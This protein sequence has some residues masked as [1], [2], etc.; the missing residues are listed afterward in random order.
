M[1]RQTWVQFNRWGSAHPLLYYT[2]PLVAWIVFLCWGSLAPP[3]ELPQFNFAQADKFEH[4]I[5]YCTLAVLLLRGW[6]R[7]RPVTLGACCVIGLIASA[8][9]L[10]LEFMQRM[11]SYRTFDLWD[12][13]SN[14]TGALL[15]LIAW[16][17]YDAWWRRSGPGAPAPP[18][19]PP[20][21]LT[22]SED[23]T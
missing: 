1:T 3:S 13:A 16:S 22:P 12:A 19:D 23:Q 11:T 10:Y 5:S 4:A 2:A 20:A 7:Q 14:A 17:L 15:G 8:W 6:V 18:P 9:G 21:P